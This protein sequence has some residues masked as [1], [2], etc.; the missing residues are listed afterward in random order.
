M[1]V[2]LGAHRLAGEFP[3]AALATSPV[4]ASAVAEL[5]QPVS[6]VG[7]YLVGH[8]FERSLKA[9]LL[10]RGMS[11][12]KLGNKPFDHNL[13]SLSRVLAACRFTR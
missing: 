7:F 2:P 6:L 1:T 3:S 4:P 12:A 9:F 8:S 5:R 10:G 13:V 11:I